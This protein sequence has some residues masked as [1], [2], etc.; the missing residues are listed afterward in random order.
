MQP[1]DGF[2]TS[3]LESLFTCIDEYLSILIDLTP[4]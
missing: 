1:V 3:L 4:T 2:S